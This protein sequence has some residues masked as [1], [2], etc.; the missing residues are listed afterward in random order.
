MQVINGFSYAKVTRDKI[1]ILNQWLYFHC[2]APSREQNKNFIS[3]PKILILSMDAPTSSPGPEV[4]GQG[5]SFFKSS[6]I[7]SET[8]K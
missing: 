3:N 2:E 8:Y 1:Q 4:Q 5:Q 6:Q 7:W